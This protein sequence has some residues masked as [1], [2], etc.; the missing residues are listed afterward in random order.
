MGTKVRVRDVDLWVDVVGDGPPLV[1]MHGGPGLDHVSL[2][3]FR[4][5]AERHRSS[6][7]TTAATAGRGDRRS[8]R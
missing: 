4:A 8:S 2:T 1:L 5:L 3:P 6:S 7:T